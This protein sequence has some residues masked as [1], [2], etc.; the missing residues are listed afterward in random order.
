MLCPNIFSSQL[1]GFQTLC[2]RF[3]RVAISCP[4]GITW[5]CPQLSCATHW[6]GLHALCDGTTQICGRERSGASRDGVPQTLNNFPFACVCIYN[7]CPDFLIYDLHSKTRRP[8][9]PFSLSLLSTTLIPLSVFRN[10][11]VNSASLFLFPRRFYPVNSSISEGRNNRTNQYKLQQ[12][13]MEISLIGNSQAKLVSAGYLVQR[14]SGC[15]G[16]LNPQIFSRNSTICFGQTTRWGKRPPIRLAL[17]AA[18][19][20]E[21][22]GS[23]SASRSGSK[24]VS[25]LLLFFGV[26]RKLGKRNG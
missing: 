15:R 11:P 5:Q 19:N 6:Y 3:A 4:L 13:S 21:A 16:K 24:P 26:L 17:K 12:S 8:I 9:F 10:S 23:T 2:D 20:S 14:E 18:A 22:R 25:F 7:Q 1:C